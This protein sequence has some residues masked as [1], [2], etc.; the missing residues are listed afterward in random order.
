MF[1]EGVSHGEDAVQVAETGDHPY[2]LITACFGLGALYLQ[3]GELPQAMAALERAATLSRVENLAQLFP[4]VA[5]PLGA[6]YAL[7]GQVAEGVSLLEAAAEKAAA[8]NFIGTQARRLAWLSEAYLLAGRWHEAM[9]LAVQA[10]DLAR[11]HKERGHEAWSLRLLG[12]IHAQQD[13][14]A[15]ESAE[16]FY[17]QAVALAEEL[18]MAPL[19]AHSLLGLGKLYARSDRPQQAR[20]DLSTAVD[21]FRAME[22]RRWLPRAEAALAQAHGPGATGGGQ[23]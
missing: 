19:L 11:A 3:Q 21:L 18:R 6:A 1:G 9:D 5:A 16:A 13:P 14:P 2:S 15:A 12:E 17:R 8:M 4:L 20:A 22:M 7:S 23:S 10:L